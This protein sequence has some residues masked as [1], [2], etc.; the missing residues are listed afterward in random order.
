MIGD[1]ISVGY[2]DGDSPTGFANYQSTGV[3][4]TESWPAQAGRRGGWIPV[5]A[6][7]SSA[8]VADFN[9]VTAPAYTRLDFTACTPDFAIL[10]LGTNDLNAG[11]QPI[12]TNY[13]TIVS[14]LTGLGIKRIYF[15]TLTPRGDLASSAGTV[16]TAAAVG[17]TSIVT[18][19]PPGT[20]LALGVG[21]TTEYAVVSSVSGSGP[22]TCTLSAGLVY[23]HPAGE[24]A[25]GGQEAVRQALNRWFR[26]MPY[27]AV[28][29]IDFDH[30]LAPAGGPNPDPRFMSSDLLHPIRSGLAL[31][32]AR[33]AD[34]R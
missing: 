32:A 25:Y 21:P 5:V 9:S 7:L 4:P 13:A 16:S 34:V 3:L 18:T 26:Q 27:G 15:A 19:M 11:R 33:A 17:A 10:A 1:S 6:G 14:I 12:M 31:M 29:V 8:G 22:Y 2:G 28:G 24:V 30:L 20:M 23:A